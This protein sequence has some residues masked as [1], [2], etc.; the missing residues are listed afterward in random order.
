MVEVS[1]EHLRQAMVK[2]GVWL[3]YA[4]CAAGLA[5]VAATWSGPNRD[6]I[7]LMFGAGIVGALLIQMLPVERLLRTRY[8]D[9]FFISWSVLDI[10]LI[11]V[12]VANDGGAASPLTYV[13]FLP[14]VFAAVFYPLR[15]F[16]PVGA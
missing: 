8:S 6:V 12:A 2:A 10:A 3:T 14:M 16:V 7:A 4:C 1:D 9:A 5:Y 15:L 11:A 13:F